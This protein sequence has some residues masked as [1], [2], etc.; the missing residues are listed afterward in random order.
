V[1]VGFENLVGDLER[2]AAGSIA[3]AAKTCRVAAKATI[4]PINSG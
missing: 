2:A 4:A 3:S 1:D